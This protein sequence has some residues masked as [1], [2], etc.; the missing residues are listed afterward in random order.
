[1]NGLPAVQFNGTAH[2]MTAG[3]FPDQAQPVTIYFVAK[4]G[5]ILNGTLFEVVMGSAGSGT[6]W[7]DLGNGG[8]V[9]GTNATY[10]GSPATDPIL[11][12]S[13][14][15]HQNTLVVNGASTFWRRDGAQSANFTLVGSDDMNGLRVGQ[16]DSS[17]AYYHGA[18]CEVLVYTGAHTST[19][20]SKVEPYLKAKWGT[21]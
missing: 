6:W 13:T 9:G 4:P 7:I 17:A 20:W 15:V 3:T 21:P 8:M 14:A 12:F 10:W 18:L 16:N 5:P 11:T 1:V 2:R 19:Q